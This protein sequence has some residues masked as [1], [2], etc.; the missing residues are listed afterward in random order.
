MSLAIQKEKLFSDIL[1]IATSYPKSTKKFFN[2]LNI[3]VRIHKIS[4]SVEIAPNIGLADGICDLVSTG[5]TLENNGLK[6]V[7]LVLES[8]AVLIESATITAEKQS[9]LNELLFRIRSIRRSK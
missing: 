7:A 5:S 1:V 2:D 8:E 9:T 3:S 4:G 6:E